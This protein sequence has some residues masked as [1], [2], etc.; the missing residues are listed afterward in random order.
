MNSKWQRKKSWQE[1]KS[2]WRFQHYCWLVYRRNWHNDAEAV[3]HSS[4]L[5]GFFI[6]GLRRLVMLATSKWK[7]VHVYGK[8]ILMPRMEA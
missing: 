5:A 1:H 7:I 4:A 8:D 6:L 3:R 2:W